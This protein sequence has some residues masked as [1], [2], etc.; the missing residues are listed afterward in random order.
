[1]VDISSFDNY[2]DAPLKSIH[3]V[4]LWKK[5]E[6]VLEAEYYNHDVDDYDLHKLTFTGVRCVKFSLDFSFNFFQSAEIYSMCIKR[7]IGCFHCVVEFLFTVEKGGSISA[8]LEF[9]FVDF[10]LEI[11]GLLYEG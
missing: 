11:N 6:L 3:F 7:E 2:H 4:F 9:E 5:V 1:M 8:S 10:I